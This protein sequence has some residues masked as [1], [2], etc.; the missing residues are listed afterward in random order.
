[1]FTKRFPKTKGKENHRAKES[2]RAIGKGKGKHNEKGKSAG[3]GKTT[4]EP[5]RG[6][7]Q[8]LWQSRTQVE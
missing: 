1:M 2:P 7:V 4:Q 3:K 5:F 6:N 8:K